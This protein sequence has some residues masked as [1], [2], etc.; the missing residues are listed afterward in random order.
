MIDSSEMLLAVTPA[1]ARYLLSLMAQGD[2]RLEI[3]R[4]ATSSCSLFIHVPP[5]G[6]PCKACP[7]AFEIESGYRYFT[8]QR[9]CRLYSTLMPGRFP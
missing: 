5:L 9:R 4:R 1:C 2:D 3:G 6:Y 7:S 8:A